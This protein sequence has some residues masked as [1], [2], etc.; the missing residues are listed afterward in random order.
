VWDIRRPLGLFIYIGRKIGQSDEA[1]DYKKS[2]RKQ[3]ARKKKHSEY[4]SYDHPDT[5]SQHEDIPTRLQ[6]EEILM[7]PV[8]EAHFEKMGMVNRFYHITA[9]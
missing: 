3:V 9:Q 6:D 4:S 5:L 8:N 1:L 7:L 2:S